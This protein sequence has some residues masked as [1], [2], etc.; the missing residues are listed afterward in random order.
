M[1]DRPYL[2]LSIFS[3]DYKT[4]AVASADNDPFFIG[5]EEDQAIIEL[6]KISRQS[7]YVKIGAVKNGDQTELTYTVVVAFRVPGFPMALQNDPEYYLLL[8]VDLGHVLPPTQAFFSEYGY[9]YNLVDENG[10][11]LLTDSSLDGISTIGASLPLTMSETASNQALDRTL[12]GQ[13][14]TLVTNKIQH[15]YLVAFLSDGK[16]KQESID[17]RVVIL[18]TTVIAIFLVAWI[19]LLTINRTLIIPIKRLMVTVN[20]RS[21]G[22]S[23]ISV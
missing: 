9:S 8:K 10:S 4:L 23:E 19:R 17:F 15:K 13:P 1:D 22:S 11:L 21:S 18:V 6:A 3:P 20:G 14:Y 2:Y 12:Q 7:I 5:N 16:I